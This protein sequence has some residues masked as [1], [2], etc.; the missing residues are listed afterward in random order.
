MAKNSK[1]KKRQQLLLQIDQGIKNANRDIIHEHI[2]PVTAESI[3]PLAVS[4]ARLRARYLE[5]AYK[6]AELEHGGA[7]DDSAIKALR[8]HQEKYETAR[9]AFEALTT[10]IERGYVKAGG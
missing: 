1:L 10:A 4:V 8:K 6:F 3:M 7:L 5:S 9:D 2:P